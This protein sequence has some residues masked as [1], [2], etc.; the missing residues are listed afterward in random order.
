MERAERARDGDMDGERW[1]AR[2]EN[3]D[4]KTK[5]HKKRRLVGALGV[6]VRAR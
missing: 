6:R 1:G 2:E 3:P 5:E 4:K